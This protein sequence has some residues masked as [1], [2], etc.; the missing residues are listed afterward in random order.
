MTAEKERQLQLAR[1]RVMARQ[2]KGKQAAA[3]IEPNSKA[4]LAELKAQAEEDKLKDARDV[5]KTHT[6]GERMDST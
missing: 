2:Q 6:Q 1:A 5:W 3:C 4:L